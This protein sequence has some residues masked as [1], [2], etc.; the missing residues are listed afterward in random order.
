MSASS[1][2]TDV[3]FQ[4]DQTKIV[5]QKYIISTGYKITMPD[6][7]HANLVKTISKYVPNPD[8]YVFKPEVYFGVH[9]HQNAPGGLTDVVKSQQ[10]M[11]NWFAK[12]NAK[13]SCTCT[14]SIIHVFIVPRIIIAEIHFGN[15]HAYAFLSN[16]HNYAT[17]QFKAALRNGKL[18]N[19]PVYKLALKNPLKCRIVPYID[20]H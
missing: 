4:P 10:F 18:N 9:Y 2:S 7:Y 13:E 3:T 5:K 20:T 12:E 17:T 16:E 19:H 11:V 8:E 6:G 14:I 15:V 1:Q